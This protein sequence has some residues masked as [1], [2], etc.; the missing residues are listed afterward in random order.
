VAFHN[1]AMANILI[2]PD[3]RD[4]PLG[5]ALLQSLTGELPLLIPSNLHQEIA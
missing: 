2:I 4:S 3:W 5:L 1:P